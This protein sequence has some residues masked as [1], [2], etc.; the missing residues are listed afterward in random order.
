MESHRKNY[1]NWKN[2]HYIYHKLHRYPVKTSTLMA[3]IMLIYD[4][5]T[6]DSVKSSNRNV[7]K[8]LIR[9]QKD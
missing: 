7:R 8:P 4:T 5:L 3:K 6:K 2:R 9:N 1:F